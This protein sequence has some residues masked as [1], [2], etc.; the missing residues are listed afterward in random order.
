MSFSTTE[1]LN[2]LSDAVVLARSR[3]EP[4]L[5]A[6]L[7]RRYEA[8]LLRR[9]R[10][11]LKSTEDAE[12][13]VQ[14]AFTKMYL[15]ADKYQPQAGA[16]FSSWAYT[17]LN[18]VA[19][20]KYRVK[21]NEFGKRAELLPEHYESLPDTRAEF[22]EDL[23]LRSE[24]LAA[25]SKLPETAAKILRLQF[26]EGKTQ[27]EIAASEQLSIPAV[28]TRIHRAKKLFKQTYDKQHYE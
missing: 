11:I 9:A 2:A 1:D 28:K 6:I 13:A 21:M 23:S 4:E 3:K 18:R 12:E 10:M 14:D 24:V 17:I 7:V 19:Y 25:L 20:T 15:Y 22:L 8:P 26:I 27:E 5:F 16:T